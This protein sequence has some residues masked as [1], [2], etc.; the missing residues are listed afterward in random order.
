MGIVQALALLWQVVG[1]CVIK[2]DK[3]LTEGPSQDRGWGVDGGVCCWCLGGKH[4][5]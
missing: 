5:K 1:W 4:T 3:L 2:N